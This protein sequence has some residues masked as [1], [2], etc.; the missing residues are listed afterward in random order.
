[1]IKLNVTDDRMLQAYEHILDSGKERFKSAIH[2]KIK[3]IP[4]NHRNIGLGKQHFTAENIRLLSKH[5]DVNLRYLFGFSTQVFGK[6]NSIISVNK[7]DSDL[8]E[9]A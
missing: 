9:S 4:Q 8:L 7:N 1:M 2:E 5:Y 6:K 3:L